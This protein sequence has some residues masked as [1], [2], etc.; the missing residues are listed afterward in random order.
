M[1]H[2]SSFD[3]LWALLRPSS[4]YQRKREACRSLWDSFP[5]ERQRIIYAAIQRA[6]QRGEG[7]HP[8]PYF[9][10]EDHAKAEPPFL[11]GT[12][13]EE[14]WADS[15]PLVQVRFNRLYKIC[16]E[17]DARSFGLTVVQPFN[18]ID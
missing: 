14:A 12:E 2:L 11:S 9:A 3:H 1:A 18:K 10:L 7:I 6:K 15:I 17:A 4:E 5:L 16:T 8:N 13:I